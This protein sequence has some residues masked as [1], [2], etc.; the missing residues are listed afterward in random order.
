MKNV[1]LASAVALISITA[2]PAFADSAIDTETMVETAAPQTQQQAIDL[3]INS[4]DLAGAKASQQYG[5]MATM[6]DSFEPG[7]RIEIGPTPDIT[8]PSVGLSSLLIP[9]EFSY[10][11]TT[12][13]SSVD[14]VNPGRFLS[15]SVRPDYLSDAGPAAADKSAVGVRFGL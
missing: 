12:Q 10:R 14:A 5:F 6:A 15:S 4:F 3:P 11:S 7:Y 9:Q 2:T 1:I 8:R 13:D